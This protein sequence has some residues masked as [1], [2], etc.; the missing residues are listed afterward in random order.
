MTIPPG[1]KL[2]DCSDMVCRLKKALYG[3]KQFP[4]K[5][6]GKLTRV[7]L[8]MNYTQSN[9]DHTMFFQYYPKG[10]QT[11]LIVYVNDI[12]ITGDYADGINKLGRIYQNILMI[13][14]WGN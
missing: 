3:L 10:K 4:R 8:G 1:Y 6:F 9:E 13:K 7:M 5:W 12:I 14:I 2:T 11:I